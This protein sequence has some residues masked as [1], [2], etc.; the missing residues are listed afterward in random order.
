MSANSPR[1]APVSGLATI[2]RI[3]AGEITAAEAFDAFARTHAQKEAALSCFVAADYGKGRTR[4]ADGPLMGLPVG[5]KDIIDTDDFPTRHGSPIYA[6]NQPRA[7]APVVAFVRRAGGAVVGKTV[8]TEFA[9]FTPRG[10]RNPWNTDY[11]PGGS[12][13]GSAAGVASGMFPFALGTQTGGSV[14]RP[15]A[16]CGVA[17]YKPTFGLIP[18]HG[19]K[20]FSPSLDTIGVFAATV[21][22]CA[23]FAAQ[24]TGRPLETEAGAPPVIGLCRTAQW[25]S[26]SAEMHAGVERAARAAADAGARVVDCELPQVFS[27]AF[28][29]HATIQDYEAARNLAWEWA[30]HRD[31]LSE[32]LR[33]TLAGGEAIGP[34]T[35]DSARRT[36]KA[37]RLGLVDVF[38]GIDVLLTPSAEGTA[39]KD[40][41]STG[42][43]TFNKLWTLMGAP[44]VNVAGLVASSGLPLGVQC[45]GPAMADQR[46]LAAAAW[47]ESVLNA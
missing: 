33:E 30:N 18:G 36:A 43:P 38:R 17:G 40:L 45:V 44:C 20:P 1:V 39:P 25:G 41:N 37:A 35:Y 12:S 13:S 23:F 21:P 3:K 7:D 5:V 14:I 26:A 47:L 2:A 4:A 32:K 22:D 27:S 28:D 10:T 16:F 19:A 46:T 15:A 11:S 31:A 6:D 29:A 8:T 24:L 34:D 42:K 9:F